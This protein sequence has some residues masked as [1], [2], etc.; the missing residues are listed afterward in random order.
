MGFGRIGQLV[1]QRALSFGMKVVA[2]DPY[3]AAERYREM[4][5]EKA[6]CSEDVYAVADFLTLHLPNTPDTRGLAGRQGAGQVQ[7]RRAGAQ[8]R[9]R[10][11]GRRRGPEGGA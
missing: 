10:A 6:E 7:G 11:A 8:R 1:A 9:P 3:V 2:F 5:V 4:G